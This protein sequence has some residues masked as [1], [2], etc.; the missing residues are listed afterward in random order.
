MRRVF[1]LFEGIDLLIISAASQVVSQ[2]VLN[3]LPLHQ[4]ILSLIGPTVK[5]IYIP[6]D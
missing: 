6:P 4:K 3:L 1:Q 5:N 2:Q